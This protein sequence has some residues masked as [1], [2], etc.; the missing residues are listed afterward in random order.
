MLVRKGFVIASCVF[1][2]TSGCSKP[3]DADWDA[4]IRG[5]LVMVDEEGVLEDENTKSMV[6]GG[7]RIAMGGLTMERARIKDTTKAKLNSY[8]DKCG[9][10]RYEY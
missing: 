1:L 9:L 10:E 8:A 6:C 7:I 4:K 2:F 3:I 5:I